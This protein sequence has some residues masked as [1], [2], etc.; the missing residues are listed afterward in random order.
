MREAIER[1]YET[2]SNYR[3][4]DFDDLGF[5]DF[6]PTDAE[7]VAHMEFYDSTW[8]TCQWEVGSGK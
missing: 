7:L 6:G 5:F 3:V 8:D 2:F 1:L 4:T